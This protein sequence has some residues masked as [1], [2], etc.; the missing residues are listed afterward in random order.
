MAEVYR[1]AHA[2]ATR[3][4]EV[5]RSAHAAVSA[6]AHENERGELLRRAGRPAEA[7]ECFAR[8]LAVIGGVDG[9]DPATHSAILN[10]LALSAHERGELAAARRYLVRSLEVGPLVG[11]PVGRAITYDN[12]AVVEV[13]LAQLAGALPPANPGREPQPGSGPR[14]SDGPRESGGSRRSHG[15]RESDGPRPNDGPRARLDDEAQARPVEGPRAEPE[16]EA[17]DRVGW[18]R[19]AEAERYFG[20]AERLF[21]S[22]LPEALDDYLRSVLNRADAAALRGDHARVDRLTRH[23]AELA[24]HHSVGADNAVEA[25]TMRGGFLHRHRGHPRAAVELLTARLPALL[26][27]CAP[28]HGAAALATLSRAAAATGDPA[29]VEDVAARMAELGSTAGSAARR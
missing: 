22:V 25:V 29:L 13:E 5:Y 18:V 19:L 16:D 24:V 17:A 26:P 10:N 6:A 20:A 1:S 12:L 3:T 11:D 28:D 9:A 21:R 15:P 27:E 7:A 14:E 8:A 2:A 23:A 4:A